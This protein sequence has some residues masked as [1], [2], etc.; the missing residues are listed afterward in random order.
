MVNLINKIIDSKK[1]YIFIIIIMTVLLFYNITNRYMFV[2]E[3]IEALIG[4]NILKFGYPKAWDG[5]NL[6]MAGVNGNEF[7]ESLI[8]IRNNW[9]PYY[10][11]AFGQYISNILGLGMQTTVGV[12]RALFS[13]IGIGGAVAFYFLAKE[14][15]DNNQ[16][17]ANV[18][19]CLFAFSIPVLLYIRSIYYLSPTLTFTITTV[20][21]YLRYVNYKKTK[22]LFVF[23]SS[24]IL[25]FHS[26]YPYFFITI[27][28]I[29]L[30]YFIFDF[31]KKTFKKLLIGASG[32]ALLTIPWYFYIRLYL[33]SVEKNV[34]SSPK[35]IMKSFLGYIW[36]IHAYFFPFLPVLLI[37]LLVFLIMRKSSKT[38][39]NRHKYGLKKQLVILFKKRRKYKGALLVFTILAINLTVISIT[40][41]FLDTRRM[42]ASIPFIFILFAYVICYIYKHIKLLG[43]CVLMISVFTNF[44][45][46]SP[47]LVLKNFNA[48]SLENFVSPPVPYFD[49]DPNWKNKKADLGEYFESMCKIESYPIYYLEEILNTYDD[50]DKGMIEFLNEYA[51]SGQKVYLIGYQ[52]ETIAFYTGLQVVNR[53]NPDENPLPTV[54]KAYPNADRFQHLTEYP[55][56]QCDWIIERRV[57]TPVQKGAVWHD[58]TKFEK[59]YIDS[60]DS[61][62][63]NEI[64]DH[65]FYTDRNFPGFY[66]YR[67]LSTTKPIS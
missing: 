40:N 25:L 21:F 28:S 24:S 15:C 4:K 41:N 57:S 32:V 46:I 49:S 66:V 65:S 31:N 12:M 1:I 64:W 51:E 8:P 9:L 36:Q 11:A 54:Y 60:P 6:A 43:V 18:S 45:H 2:D 13:L 56:E 14:M 19:L 34:F 44:L 42:I 10:I 3:S 38:E 20:L 23:L 33:N 53:L 16:T 47:Y 50:A 5:I 39:C 7:N 26:F 22:D 61:K 67:N 17:I 37:A 55:I 62:P 30:I 63:W 59:I 29:I 35:I 58:E 48:S 27:F 52:Y